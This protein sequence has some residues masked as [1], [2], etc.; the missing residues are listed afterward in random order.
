M[1]L[2]AFYSFYP[3]SLMSC[4]VLMIGYFVLVMQMQMQIIDALFC[5]RPGREIH[6]CTIT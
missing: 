3:F 5:F 6:C 2:Y 1:I 4:I